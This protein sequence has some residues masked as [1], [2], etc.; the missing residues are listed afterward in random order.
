ML[1][2]ALITI[3]AGVLAASSVIVTKRPDA[4]K[5]ID[6]MVPYQGFIGIAVFIFGIY[7]LLG[8]IGTTSWIGSGYLLLW[9]VS[10]VATVGMLG[11]GFI[12]GYALLS[13]YILSKNAQAAAKGEEIRVKLLKYQIPLGFI[14]IAVGVL[15]LIF[16]FTFRII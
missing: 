4:K 13:K 3:A 7:S 1:T 6:K 16:S 14:C 11:V 2:S 5:I 15:Y 10:L 12:L 9:I 8:V